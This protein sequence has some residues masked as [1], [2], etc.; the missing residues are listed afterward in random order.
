[1]KIEAAPAQEQLLDESYRDA[2]QR[3]GHLLAS[4][5]R[6]EHEVR[7]RLSVAGYEDATVERVI[8]RLLEL[9]LLDDRGFALQW[10]SERAVAK[11]RSG[12]ALVAELVG[13]GI[14]RAVAESA[15]ADAGIDEDAQ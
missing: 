9:R 3:A 10:V 5:P 12:D 11:G 4:R 14:D 6:T 13:K 2:M 15:V 1:M 8:T 7:V